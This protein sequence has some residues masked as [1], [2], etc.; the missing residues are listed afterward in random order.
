[1]FSTFTSIISCILAALI[2]SYIGYS[3]EKKNNKQIRADAIEECIEKLYEVT[4]QT[5]DEKLDMVFVNALREL[6]SQKM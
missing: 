2:G 4:P 5:A 6:K 3:F 1:M